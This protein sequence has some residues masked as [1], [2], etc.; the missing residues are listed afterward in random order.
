MSRILD[1]EKEPV[2]ELG[3]EVFPG[4]LLRRCFPEPGRGGVSQS[5]IAEMFPGA[6]L[7]SPEKRG[8]PRCLRS[9]PVGPRVLRGN[10]RNARNTR[11]TI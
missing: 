7:Q 9:K 2:I 4:A 3:A 1:L 5:L 10:A 6:W 11:N 8:A